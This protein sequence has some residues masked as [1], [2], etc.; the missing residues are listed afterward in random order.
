VDSEWNPDGGNVVEM[1]TTTA[2]Q[3]PLRFN[4]QPRVPANV[5]VIFL[6][7]PGNPPTLHCTGT[8]I[9]PNK[10]LTAKHCVLRLKAD[11]T[12]TFGLGNRSDNTTP[13]VRVSEADVLYRDGQ[14]G[15][16][17]SDVAVL[18]LESAI[19]DV[20]P[21]A[22]KS[23]PPGK[24]GEGFTF[25][26]FGD[27]PASRAADG[28]V[29]DPVARE[30]PRPLHVVPVTVEML[31]GN[32]FDRI[33]G[34]FDN[35]S[36]HASEAFPGL[37][38]AAFPGHLRNGTARLRLRSLRRQRGRP[39]LLRR[40]WRPTSRQRRKRRRSRFSGTRCRMQAWRH[41]CDLR[42]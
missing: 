12:L 8:L 3:P 15:T 18:T 27:L 1:N 16:R 29:L 40:L 17:G 39:N 9:A 7:I 14:S 19:P 28:H 34:N 41:L 38:A 25:A 24:T 2:W 36:T 31:E 6:A 10:V 13:P 23:L 22:W 20:V 5:G 11:A 37:G 35:F 42:P 30:A 21:A 26:G 4:E 33:Y 32:A